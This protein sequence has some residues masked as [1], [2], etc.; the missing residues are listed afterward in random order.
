MTTV[1][2]DEPRRTDVRPADRRPADAATVRA[3]ARSA[4]LAAADV[5][6]TGAE[7]DV[8]TV[9]GWAEVAL[10]C[11]AL[12]EH[13]AAF[14]ALDEVVADS[15]IRAGGPAA[16]RLRGLRA[17][18]GRVPDRYPSARLPQPIPPVGEAVWERCARLARFCDGL[19]VPRAPK[20][21]EPLPD[22]AAAQLTWGELLRPTP[23][24]R[25]SIVDGARWAGLAGRTWMTLPTALGTRVVLIDVPRG[26]DRPELQRR[27]WRGVHDGAHLDLLTEG[28]FEF[29]SGLL[30]AE[31]YAMAV[32]AV[33]LVEACRDGD[34]GL[35]WWLRYG[36]AERIGRLPGFPGRGLPVAGPTLHMAVTCTN[37]EFAGLPTIAAS[38]ITGPIDLLGGRAAELLP[39][40][41]ADDLTARWAAAAGQDSSET[42][43]ATISAISA[44]G[45]AI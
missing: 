25:Y 34:G 37:L 19:P 18:E 44:F 1:T 45:M 10:G 35:A 40:R 20:A 28:G 13:A 16:A 43:R 17:T 21:P 36:M 4:A 42:T 32:E 30:V 8:W 7:A 39:A 12:T 27:I 14:G 9:R 33:A 41:L 2:C 15:G 22:T 26:P 5:P 38:Y 3:W 11:A 6:A 24:R 29:G 23:S 31:A